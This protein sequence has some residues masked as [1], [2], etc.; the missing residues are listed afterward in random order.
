MASTGR[1]ER[2]QEEDQPGRDGRAADTE[3]MGKHPPGAAEFEMLRDLAAEGRRVEVFEE[4]P[5]G[6]VST[7]VVDSAEAEVSEEDL[8]GAAPVGVVDFTE[9]EVPAE[10]EV[11]TAVDVVEKL[12]STGRQVLLQEILQLKR[13]GCFLSIRWKKHPTIVPS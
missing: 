7:G 9:V 13:E 2:F 12:P 5:P 6:A 1:L 8:Q 10:V 4:D 11:L 3:A